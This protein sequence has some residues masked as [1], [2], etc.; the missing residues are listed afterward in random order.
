MIIEEIRRFM[1]T[2]PYLNGNKRINVDFLPD[3]AIEYTIDAVPSQTLVKRYADGGK[4]KQFV[5]TFASKEKY[6]PEVIVNMENNGFYEKVSNWIENES[7]NN[8]LPN[9]N[10]EKESMYMEVLDSGYLFQA[11]ENKARY[12]MQLRLVYYEN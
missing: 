2:C 8:N 11:D 5:F 6:G 1:R 12:Q 4:V 10:D 7:E 9:L 3:K